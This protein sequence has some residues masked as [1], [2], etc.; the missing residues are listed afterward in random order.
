MD[1]TQRIIEG[2]HYSSGKVVRIECSDG[3]IHS[4]TDVDEKYPANQ[5]GREDLPMVAPALTDLQVNGYKGVD[6]HSPV[7]NH[8]Q[9]IEAIQMLAEIGVCSFYP[10]FITGNPDLI[11]ANLKTIAG[12]MNEGEE[13]S[14]NLGGIH[15]E[16]PFISAE[17]GP[18]GAHAKEYCRLPDTELVKRWQ[19]TARGNIRI[20]TLA[21]EL[22]GSEELIKTCV[23]LN[24]VVAIG[25]TAAGVE[26][27]QRAVDAGAR[28]STHLGNGAHKVMLRHPNYIW[29][30]LAE[31]GLFASMIADNFHLGDAVLK[32][33]SH[34]KGEK[35]ILV[36]DCMCYAGM[37]PGIY[38]TSASGRLCLTKEGKLHMKGQPGRLAGS[39][40]TLPEGIRRMAGLIGFSDAWDM[41]SVNPARLMHPGVPIGLNVGA[42]DKLVFLKDGELMASPAY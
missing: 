12:V 26:D 38:E 20:I 24:M 27:I 11:S 10:T 37:E 3:F 4:I 30:Q 31:E 39:A 32:V 29:E 15:L 14:R 34:V 21:P 16:G 8:D 36:S 2:I 17:D 28:L 19:E 7:L 40:A 22:P 25:H 18:R 13:I 42:V 41:A 5:A 33:F 35:G 23:K 6:F 9:V 1:L